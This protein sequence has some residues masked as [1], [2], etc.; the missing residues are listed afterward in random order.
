MA[1]TQL[2]PSA[3]PSRLPSVTPPSSRPETPASSSSTSRRPRKKKKSSSQL[4]TSDIKQPNS[5]SEAVAQ[6]EEAVSSAAVLLAN[7]DAFA[8]ED[9]IQFDFDGAPEFAQDEDGDPPPAPELAKSKDGPVRPW[10]KGKVPESERA[11]RKR[12][13]AEVDSSDG[14]ASKRQRMDAASRRAPW[15]W[16]VDWDG[17]QNVAQMLHEEVDAF[18]KYISPTPV[19]D[20]VR[21]MIV[22]IIR[23]EVVASFPDAQVLPF[24]SYETKLYLPLGDI[25]LVI[26]SPSMAYSR[27]QSVLH[28]LASTMKRAGI[29]DRVT[30]IAK[31]KVPIIKF[32]T[33][34]GRFAV[35]I[36]VNQNNGVAAGKI[37]KQF[38][39]E[40][41]ALRALVL[42][43]KS[44]LNQ[45]SMNEV[46]TGGLG[47]YSIVCLAISFL[48]MHPKIRRGEINA[49]Q[50]LG[51]LV[52]EFFE[53]YGRYFNYDEVG[54]SLREGGSYYNKTHRGWSDYRNP[55]LLSIEDPGDPSNDISRGTYHI[56]K[57]R[58]TLAGAYGIMTSAAYLRAG[59][60][61]ARKKHRAVHL[62]EVHN[63]EEMSIL[64]SVMGVTQETVNHRRLTQEVYDSRVL[65]RMLGIE[66]DSVTFA[67][68]V[69]H[70]S[71]SSRKPPSSKSQA[72]AAESVKTAWSE[73]ELV[74]DSDDE[75]TKVEEEEES[76]YRAA[77][78]R[79]SQPPKKRRRM[80]KEADMHTVYTTDDDE[81]GDANDKD[82]RLHVGGADDGVTDEEAEYVVVSDSESGDQANKRKKDEKRSYWLSKGVGLGGDTDETSS[83]NNVPP[84]ALKDR[85]A[86]LQQQRTG[87]GPNDHHS[88]PIA[89]SPSQATG[90]SLKDKIAN[91]E[92]KGAVPT[93]RGSF[94]LG[95][96]PVDDGASKRKGELYGNRVPGLS[97]P[98]ADSV[99][100]TSRHRAASTSHMSSLSISR[101]PSPPVPDM[102]HSASRASSPTFNGP[103]YPSSMASAMRRVVSE[104]FLPTHES[105]GDAGK[106]DVAPVAEEA[107]VED[108]EKEKEVVE[109]EDHPQET[110]K[111][112]AS[113]VVESPE[114]PT[115]AV[116]T[117]LLSEPSPG[118]VSAASTTRSSPSFY[119]PLG[120]MPPTPYHAAPPSALLLPSARSSP[121][122]S[123]LEPPAPSPASIISPR[124][125]D[126]I[127][128]LE[129]EYSAAELAAR[130]GTVPPELDSVDDTSASSDAV[131]TPKDDVFDHSSSQ[132]QQ[133]D[134][135]KTPDSAHTTKPTI[136]LDVASVG[137]PTLRTPNSSG[138]RPS[139]GVSSL[140]VGED[141]FLGDKSLALDAADAIIVTDAPKIISPARASL[142]PVPRSS[143]S[144]ASSPAVSTPSPTQWVSNLEEQMSANSTR[145][146][147]HA[148]VHRKVKEPSASPSVSQ[149]PTPLPVSAPVSPEVTVDEP[150]VVPRSARRTSFIPRPAS[151][152]RA[153][154]VITEEPP[155]SPGIGDLA[156]L[157]QDAAL[158]EEQLATPSPNKAKKF[159]PPPSAELT[160]TPPPPSATVSESSEPTTP[161]QFDAPQR[162]RSINVDRIEEEETQDSFD[163]DDMPLARTMMMF[164]TPRSS[165]LPYLNP[166]PPHSPA[167]LRSADPRL[168]HR[169]TFP[170]QPSP[171]GS[172]TRLSS[173]ASQTSARTRL[174]SNAS[175]KSSRTR[176]QSNASQ[177]VPPTP[178]PK[179]PSG[180]APRYFSSLRMRKPSMPGTFPRTSYSSEDSSMLATPP[181]T[182]DYYPSLDSQSV[183][184]DA[185]SIRS[186][187]KSLKS[188]KRSK[189]SGK[190]SL[191]RAT[192][193]VEKLWRGGKG[194]GSASAE[195]DDDSGAS[196]QSHLSPYSL[197]PL[198]QIP[199]QQRPTSWVSVET[200]GSGGDVFD[201]D[202]FDS[203][204]SVP[205]SA[206]ANGH[207]QYRSTSSHL[208]SSNYGP[209]S[210]MGYADSR[211]ASAT[212]PGAHSKQR[213]AF[214]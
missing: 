140:S 190:S 28:A 186:S 75:V 154:I 146:S 47:S 98:S 213:S 82:L 162:P 172:R 143:L 73:A 84:V 180:T 49:E 41:P 197:P 207:R 121:G 204:P 10:D 95:A 48:Q 142:I 147:F 60:I 187:S 129:R 206:P 57:V 99:L 1:A 160:I 87:Q 2:K 195:N 18:V 46:F 122:S 15:A 108:G 151:T 19:E 104:V 61:E 198:P 68:D 58:T 27:S 189:S 119:S 144:P 37:I 165:S 205:D 156:M 200:T 97:K 38:M 22:Q 21:S 138:T 166:T 50:N 135:V 211:S 136:T 202:L 33:R 85:I 141:S 124:R 212:L 149:P 134:E 188:P 103:R 23:R 78:S 183:R 69:K 179:S 6:T 112:E 184:S 5:L 8:D 201:R 71:G 34:H 210:E 32:V 182:A 31:A 173:N 159:Q 88:Q 51:T 109:V 168:E 63:P 96:P 14:Y 158:L 170:S 74:M 29:T 131:P 7:Q 161:R 214:I 91:F 52:M 116:S 128:A 196:S 157:L 148:V 77:D 107:G 59:V 178:P 120:K 139:S 20:D 62:R 133:P 43:I 9:F 65:H 66:A 114:K 115:I 86:L 150:K 110:E 193:V 102:P 111:I 132:K 83:R 67:I 145:Q 152:V 163:V 45:R 101:M 80:G 125:A 40:L 12:K 175:Q 70:D 89:I 39:Q 53:L 42:I 55:G 155:E 100:P 167:V 176:L 126:L 118:P 153:S 93:P 181:S 72:R 35:D 56:A 3:G 117:T 208:A 192:S 199:M 177:E 26:V 79:S 16:D 76:R 127:Q 13:V 185:S 106:G 30:V 171:D 123:P 191:G 11:G 81:D 44:F 137:S 194:K 92:R 4:N 203:F 130:D 17:C 113:P 94:G 164:P 174:Q 90:S 105:E 169:Q 36:S 209:G 54:I 64:A 25:D 24:G